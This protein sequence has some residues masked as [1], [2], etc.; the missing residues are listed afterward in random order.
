MT[1]PCHH[2][3]QR[4]AGL[5]HHQCRERRGVREEQMIHGHQDLFGVEPELHSH[6]F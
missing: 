4:A 6:G 1:A 2:K 5:L 3:V